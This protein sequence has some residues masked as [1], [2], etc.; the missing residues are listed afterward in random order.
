M[1]L[2]VYGSRLAGLLC[3]IQDGLQCRLVLLTAKC[4]SHLL[5]EIVWA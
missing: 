5:A 3:S 2:T 1:A 4:N